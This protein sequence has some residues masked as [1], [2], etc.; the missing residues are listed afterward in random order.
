MTKAYTREIVKNTPDSHQTSPAYVLTFVRWA[1]RDT[2]NYSGDKFT[3]RKPMVVIN[4]C[5]DLTVS[6]NKRNVTSSCTIVLKSGD[7]NYAT[8]LSPGDF[9]TA[10]I[11][12]SEGE[13]DGLVEKIKKSKPINHYKDGFK[14]VF[15]VQK[16]S[17]KFSVSP[18]T[19]IKSYF[20]IVQA[21][22]FTELNTLIYFNP[23]AAAA[24]QKTRLFFLAQ[25]GKNVSNLFDTNRGESNI[26]DILKRLT[27]AMLGVG[28]KNKKEPTMPTTQN[29]GFI[30]PKEIAELL[31]RKGAKTCSDIYN[32]IIGTWKSFKPAGQDKDPGKMFNQYMKSFGGD[33]TFY[34]MHKGK[35]EG[36]KVLSPSDFNNKQI[37]SVLQSYSNPAVNESY[38]T[39]RIG[40]DGYVY[41]TVIF[42]QKPF[43]SLHFK[44]TKHIPLTRFLGLPRWKVSPDLITGYELGKDE[45]ARINF[46]QV[47]GRSMSMC[48]QY[49]SSLQAT[50]IFFDQDDIIKHGMKPVTI[51]TG[52]DYPIK[53]KNPIFQ[54]KEWSELLFDMLNA[55]QLRESG[56]VTCIGI[57]EPIAV[58]DNLEFDNSV[59][60]IESITHRYAVSPDGR[61]IFRTILQ[62]TFGTGLDS[63]KSKP[64]YPQMDNQDANAERERDWFEGGFLPGI[65]DVQ[66]LPENPNRSDGEKTKENPNTS[67][68][69]GAETGKRYDTIKFDEKS[70]EILSGKHKDTEKGDKKPKKD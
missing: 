70:A 50:N 42:R 20:Y 58:G 5:V 1:N 25:F 57:Q 31:N 12:N 66:H 21:Y 51:T 52:F 28:I 16:V 37:W 35:L 46:I 17:R 13:R 53:E 7:I 27:K 9:V 8:A 3:A 22:G 4:D 39:T 56:N 19:G 14:G 59:Y 69:L 23:T 36:W 64:V 18:E 41:P 62:V 60:H 48:D 68:T 34:K 33:E 49:N 55:G 24:F 10:N 2:V 40:E 6:E 47:Y 65:T 67:F 32:F 15:K 45:A 63:T 38:T 61:K 11:V 44:P 43:T 30:Y 26:A 54:A 29:K